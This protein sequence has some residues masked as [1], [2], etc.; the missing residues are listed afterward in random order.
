MSQR[1]KQTLK[2]L[3]NP[4]VGKSFTNIPGR[5][6]Q[7]I[8]FEKRCALAAMHLQNEE[9]EMKRRLEG[10]QWATESRK[11]AG[12]WRSQAEKR[13]QSVRTIVPPAVALHN[14]AKSGNAMDALEQKILNIDEKL[15]KLQRLVG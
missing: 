5:E 4:V 7:L 6:I 11:Q 8:N 10:G 1:F 13:W 3:D 15:E 12:P 2:V 14:F 9:E